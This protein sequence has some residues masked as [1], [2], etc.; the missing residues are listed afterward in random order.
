LT[1]PAGLP[2]FRWEF[3]GTA[4]D[5]TLI[6]IVVDIFDAGTHKEI[7]QYTRPLNDGEELDEQVEEA[8]DTLRFEE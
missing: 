7:L 3:Q 2:Y 6:R 4:E 8:I 5:G 1:T